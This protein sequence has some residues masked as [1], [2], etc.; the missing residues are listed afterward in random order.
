MNF[1]LTSPGSFMEKNCH[2][3]MVHPV[4][5]NQWWQKGLQNVWQKSGRGDN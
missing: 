3:L 5:E 2:V 1:R 4:P